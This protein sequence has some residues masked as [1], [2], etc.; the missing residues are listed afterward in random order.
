MAEDRMSLEALEVQA[1]PAE[2]EPVLAQAQA[3]VDQEQVARVQEEPE[4]VEAS[5]SLQNVNQHSILMEHEKMQ[6]GDN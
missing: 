4:V 2:P 5:A 1:E 6:A 3:Q